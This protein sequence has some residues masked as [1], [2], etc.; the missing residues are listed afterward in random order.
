[1]IVILGLCF[2]LVI[3]VCFKLDVQG[4]GGGRIA[5]VDGQGVEVLKIGEFSWTS[6]VYHP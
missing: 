1:M 5:D 4:G 2:L 6:N 3:R